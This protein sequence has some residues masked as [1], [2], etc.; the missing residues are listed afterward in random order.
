MTVLKL[1]ENQGTSQVR[2][3]ESNEHLLQIGKGNVD[4]VEIMVAGNITNFP[5][6]L[7]TSDNMVCNGGEPQI[8]ADRQSLKFTGQIMSEGV[9]EA[10]FT[11]AFE[12]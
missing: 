6:R 10:D 12:S 11:M 3:F 8:S 5:K 1:V 2:V 7:T 9:A 4:D